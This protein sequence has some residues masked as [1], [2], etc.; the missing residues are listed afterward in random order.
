ML[1]YDI[2]IGLSIYLLALAG[3]YFR[4]NQK[5]IKKYLAVIISFLIFFVLFVAYFILRLHLHEQM[6]LIS[7]VQSEQ[8]KFFSISQSVIGALIFYFVIKKKSKITIPHVDVNK[9]EP[10]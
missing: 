1:I 4:F 9:I 10:K 5:P 8:K 7:G 2:A 6:E 3:N